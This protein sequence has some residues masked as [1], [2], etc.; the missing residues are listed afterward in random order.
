MDQNNGGNDRAGNSGDSEATSNKTLS[1]IEETEK[2]SS[3]SNPGDESSPA[4]DG[5][6]DETMEKDK[7][8]P[9]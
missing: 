1:D 3:S 6:F 5:Q 4:P 7:A 2:D 8:G 9:M